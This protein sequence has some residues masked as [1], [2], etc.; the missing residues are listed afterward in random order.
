MKVAQLA[1]LVHT[2]SYRAL[3]VFAQ[4]EETFSVITTLSITLFQPYPEEDAYD[5][6]RNV[7]VLFN[8]FSRHDK[9]IT[10]R[11]LAVYIS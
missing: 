1:S 4:L 7:N 6:G 10:W 9:L 3:I 8:I 11:T 5:S 2:L